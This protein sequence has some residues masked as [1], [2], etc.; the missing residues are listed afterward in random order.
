MSD[1]IFG[2]KFTFFLKIDETLPSGGWFM[3][4]STLTKFWYDFCQHFC[5]LLPSSVMLSA[6]VL[7]SCKTMCMKTYLP[8]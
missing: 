4:L 3:A 1:M 8:I 5:H 7:T 2:S 6:P